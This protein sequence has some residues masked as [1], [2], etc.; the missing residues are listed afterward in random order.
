MLSRER[1]LASEVAALKREQ[2]MS[3]AFGG[4]TT[5]QSTLPSPQ[6]AAIP[7]GNSPMSGMPPLSLP[8]QSFASATSPSRPRMRSAS[9]SIT[10][11]SPDEGGTGNAHPWALRVLS[12]GLRGLSMTSR[13]DE[14]CFGRVDFVACTC[15]VGYQCV[16]ICVPVPFCV[17]R[18]EYVILRRCWGCVCACVCVCVHVRVRACLHDV[19]SPGL[20]AFPL[21]LASPL[22]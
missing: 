3:G 1:S 17:V 19:L 21:H 22:H 14:C 5:P 12:C 11:D 8:G 2:A 18:C 20:L 15:H 9:R 4:R 13:S 10:S 16:V 6:S 7:R